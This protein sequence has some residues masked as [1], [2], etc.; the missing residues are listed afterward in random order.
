MKT[1]L[2]SLMFLPAILILSFAFIVPL[3]AKPISIQA[4]ILVYPDPELGDKVLLEFPFAV[5]RNQFTFMPNDSMGGFLLGAVFAEVMLTDQNGKNVDSANIYFLTRARDTVDA[6]DSESRLFNQLSLEVKPGTYSGKLTVIDVIN[7]NEGTFL[8]DRIE[9][10]PPIRNRL[11]LSSIEF[12]HQISDAGG[13][14]KSGNPVLVKSGRSIIPDPMGLYAE[15]DSTMYI[16]AELYNI[17]YDPDIRDSFLV[18][19]TILDDKGITYHQFSDYWQIK[20]GTSSAISSALNISDVWPGR[21]TLVMTADDFRSGQADTVKSSFIKFPKPG[22][23]GDLV[24]YRHRFPYDSI[25][26]ETKMR[27]TRYLLSPQDMA[28]LNELN[29]AGKDRF[30]DQYFTDHDTDPTTEINEYLNDLYIRYLYSNEHFSS[31]PGYGDGW[32]RDRGRVLMQYGNWDERQEELTPAYGKAFEIW[33]YYK[34]QKGGVV[35]VFQDVGG[36]GDFKLVHSTAEGEVFNSEWDN[37]IKGGNLP[38]DEQQE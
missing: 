13:Q 3:S 32:S 38:G 30:L 28:L 6:A 24:A 33:K 25:G 20:P 1:L 31:L 9:V 37:F 16:Y 2:L 34:L 29:D 12:A 4:G 8:Y 15:K 5:H 21:Y 19:Y 26:L 27:L 14:N 35:F 10:N 7:K 36:Y 23:A 18:Q 22:A 17:S 11:K